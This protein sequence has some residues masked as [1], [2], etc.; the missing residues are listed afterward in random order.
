MPKIEKLY[1]LKHGS[2]RQKNQLKV[3]KMAA[4]SIGPGREKLY[5]NEAGS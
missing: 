4:L 1:I 2:K 3:L 5:N